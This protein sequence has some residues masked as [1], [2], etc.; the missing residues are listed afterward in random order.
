MHLLFSGIVGL[1]LDIDAGEVDEFHI[2]T[3]VS[4]GWPVH[5]A[6]SVR[7]HFFSWRG[8]VSSSVL[9]STCSVYGSFHDTIFSYA[10]VL[11]AFIE[12][13]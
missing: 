12:L 1:D 2:D 6:M 7:L 11:L 9:S 5:R 13:A 8:S 10:I 4:V 3:F